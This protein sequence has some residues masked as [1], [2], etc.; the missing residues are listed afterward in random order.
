M[1]FLQRAG[2]LADNESV[3]VVVRCRPMSGKEELSGCF[4]VVN[5]YPERGV[6][7][8]TNP[9]AKTEN[10]KYKIFTYDGVYDTR[11]VQ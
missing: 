9:K 3:Q 10:E 4:N 2:C 1:F 6:I 11:C 7:E 5:V 8:V